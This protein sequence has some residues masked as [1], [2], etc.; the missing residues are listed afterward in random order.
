MYIFKTALYVF[1]VVLITA[2]LLPLIK[3]DFWIFRVFDYPRLQKFIC[4]IILCVLWVFYFRY[5]R[6]GYDYIIFIILLSCLVYLGFLVYPF[7]PFGK[8]MIAKV[9]PIANMPILTL[10]VANVF[11][12]NRNYNQLLQ[13]VDRINPDI[14]FLVETDDDWLEGV[15]KIR[16]EF[17][18]YIEVPR[19]NTY[20][21]L[22]YSKLPRIKQEINYLMNDEIPSITADV[23]FDN[24]TI[25][26]FGLHPM[27]P[28]PQE[29]EHSTDRDAEILMIGKLAKKEKGPCLVIGDLNDVAWSYTTEL[30]LKTSGLLDPRRGRGLFSTFHA[31]YPFFRWPL[32][33]FFMSSHFRLVDMVVAKNIGSDHFPI[34]IRLIISKEDD[35]NQLESTAE[36]EQL[37]EKKIKAGQENDPR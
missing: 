2:V 1:S 21:I 23:E 35:T 18:F 36:D 7:T 4:I 5:N 32:D 12:E 10:L 34:S 22:F 11:Q 29:S 30:F 31:K 13:L 15:K 16:S 37:A 17:P 20:G 24:H 25:K 3:K 9:K 6:F 26:I 14:L 19:K 28:M 33:H 8:E 27:P